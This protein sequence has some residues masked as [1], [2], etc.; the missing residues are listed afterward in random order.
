M[1]DQNQNTINQTIP[2][3]TLR[4]FLLRRK[5]N[6]SQKSWSQFDNKWHDNKL[7]DEIYTFNIGDPF[8]KYRSPDST[9]ANSTWVNKLEILSPPLLSSKPEYLVSK[10][11]TE[12]LDLKFKIVV[13]Y[14]INIGLVI[15]HL[16]N[17]IR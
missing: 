4:N 1:N 12:I 15:L 17:D 14:I 5:L 10:L 16:I 13:L 8:K 3:F 2:S 7:H 11:Q 9:W 6:L